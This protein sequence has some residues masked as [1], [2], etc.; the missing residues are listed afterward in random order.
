MMKKIIL[1]LFFLGA[2]EFSS[3]LSAQVLK[4]NI[5][6]NKNVVKTTIVL[7]SFDKINASGI[8]HIILTQSDE[9]KNSVTIETDENLLQFIQP[10]VRNQ[11]LSFSYKNISPSVLKFYVSVTESLSEIK[12]SGASSVNDLFVLS[13]NKIKLKSSGAASTKLMLNYSAVDLENSGAAH[14]IL[15]GKTRTLSATLSGASRLNA[16][17]MTVDSLLFEGSG[18]A[19]AKARVSTY[20][21]KIISGTAHL[22]LVSIPGKNLDVSTNKKVMKIVKVRGNYSNIDTTNVKIG[23]LQVQVV[24]GDTTKINIGNHVLIVDQGGHVKWLRKNRTKKFRGHWAGVGLGLNGYVNPQFNSNFGMADSYLSLRFE[25][26]M[27]VN[28]NFFEQ[29]IPLNKAKTI[30]MVTGL[31]LSF[32]DYRFSNPTYLDNSAQQLTGYF[33]R[34]T[35]V[36]KSKLSATYLSVPLLFEFQDIADKRSRRFFMSF[37]IIGNVKIHSHTK[38]YFNDPNEPYRLQDPATGNYLSPGYV[39]PGKDNRNIMK[40]TSGYFLNPF[41]VDATIRVGFPLLS[42]Y[43]SYGLTPMFQTGKGPEVHQWTLGVALVSW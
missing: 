26:S 9:G 21:R 34:E 32:N 12:A 11:V 37:G 43:A 7:P 28:L 4:R 30:G 22:S 36:R 18:A 42:L 19:S 17:G 13:G 5:K 23:T 38:I 33:I 8:D 20:V 3:T 29:N 15:T 27:N 39:T 10:Q 25:K 16:V 14:S 31:G 2:I 40:N 1:F 41:R 24:D 6:G 35:S